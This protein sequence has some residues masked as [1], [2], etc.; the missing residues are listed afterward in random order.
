MQKWY[1][2]CIHFRCRHFMEHHSKGEKIR[3]GKEK[4]LSKNLKNINEGEKFSETK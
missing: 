3:Q 2:V 4:L 1:I